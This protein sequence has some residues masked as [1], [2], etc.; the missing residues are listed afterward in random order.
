MF[1]AFRAA[2]LCSAM[3]VVAAC[4][5]GSNTAT[6]TS[7]TYGYSLTV[8]AG[9]TAT[10]ASSKWD[11][12]GMPGHLEPEDDL[13]NSP[14]GQI[15]WGIAAPTT[16]DLPGYVADRIAANYAD[17]GDTCPAAP[18]VQEP[19]EVGG[20]AG[21]FV[22]WDCGLL[23]NLA[24]TAHKGTGYQ[25]VLRDQNVHAAT[26][27]ADRAVFAALLRSVRFP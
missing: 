6:F 23:I 4:S 18:A 14:T 8:P 13:F 2:F 19:I 22:A 7:K 20:Q 12:N 11:G 27:A 15:A 17:H 9:W 24:V 3:L 16:K 5:G 21:S 25:F 1:N 10:E 26:D